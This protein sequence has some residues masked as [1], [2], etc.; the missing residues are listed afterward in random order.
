M[1]VVVGFVWWEERGEEE[2]EKKEDEGRG[3]VCIDDR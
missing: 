2:G 1:V 3:V